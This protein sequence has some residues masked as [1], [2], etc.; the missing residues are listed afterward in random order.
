MVPHRGQRR[1]W[2]SNRLVVG[3]ARLLRRAL[4][5][6]GGP[7]PQTVWP[8]LLACPRLT[9]LP[10]GLALVPSDLVAGGGEKALKQPTA[11]QLVLLRGT[12]LVAQA[13][14]PSLSRRFGAVLN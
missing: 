11:G 9:C 6:S 8:G 13:S 7:G 2:D 1:A 12:G 4:W 14:W 5:C 10:G 3:G